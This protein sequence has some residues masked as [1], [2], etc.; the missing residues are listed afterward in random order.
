M[1][2]EFRDD[3]DWRS[4]AY[5]DADNWPEAIPAMGPK[6]EY[7]PWPWPEPTHDP[8][9]LDPYPDSHP[10]AAS[11]GDLYL[12][13]VCPWCGVPLRWDQ[14]VVLIDKTRGVF[15][16]ISAIDDPAVAYH[17]GCHAERR[18]K[19]NRSLTDYP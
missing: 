13:D 5:L 1:S 10:N 6:R 7:G 14:T 3:R 17:P 2:S 19:L 16:E 12:G 15:H 11:I 9:G 8:E 4:W 18:G